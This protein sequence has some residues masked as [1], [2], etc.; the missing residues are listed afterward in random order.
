VEHSNLFWPFSTVHLRDIRADTYPTEFTRP[1]LLVVTRFSVSSLSVDLPVSVPQRVPNL[2][3]S[4]QR[5]LDTS[6]RILLPVAARFDKRPR[7][8]PTDSITIHARYLLVQTPSPSYEGVSKSFRTESITKYMLTTINTRCEATQ[9][10]MAAKLIILT[11]KI[12]IKLHLVAERCIICSS[13]SRLPVRK[14]LDTPAYTSCLYLFGL[15]STIPLNRGGSTN[16]R[17]WRGQVSSHYESSL[18]TAY[19]EIRVTI[20]PI[21]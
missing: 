9:R 8:F 17:Q 7:S 6:P 20:P 19:K 5:R 13:C 3:C 1:L 4:Y 18:W 14:L 15:P 21:Q 11:H 2:L 12:A 10:V 16:S